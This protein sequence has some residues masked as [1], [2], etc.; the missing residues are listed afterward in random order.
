MYGCCCCVGSHIEHVYL[1]KFPMT[2]HTV[3]VRRP[4]GKNDKVRQP[5]ADICYCYSSYL[6][7]KNIKLKK[8]KAHKNTP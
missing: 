2:A 5:N 6:E 1:V 4:F 3:Y 8:C 7:K